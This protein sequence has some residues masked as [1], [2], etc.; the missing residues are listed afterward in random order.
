MAAEDV[1]QFTRTKW[2]RGGK[3]GGDLRG[4]AGCHGGRDVAVGSWG[5]EVEGEVSAAGCGGLAPP[6]GSGGD[7][8][9]IFRGVGALL[10]F[11]RLFPAV[12]LAIMISGL[13][14]NSAICSRRSR[15]GS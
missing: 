3:Q 2:E 10:G 7:A 6:G 11:R 15:R 13:R 8:L 1:E 9:R 12:N 5:R 14:T 4:E